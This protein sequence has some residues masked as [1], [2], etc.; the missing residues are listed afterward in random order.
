MSRAQVP[1]AVDPTVEAYTSSAQ[2]RQ[3]ANAYQ[4]QQEVTAEDSRLTTRASPIGAADVS[5]IK[6][7]EQVNVDCG[8]QQ[9]TSCKLAG[10]KA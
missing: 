6:V 9:D 2:E 1:L 4:L 5:A 8:P 10:G 7:L 3:P